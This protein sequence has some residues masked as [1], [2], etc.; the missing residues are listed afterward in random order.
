MWVRLWLLAILFLTACGPPPRPRMQSRTDDFV[1]EDQLAIPL[2][3]SPSG[4][5]DLTF[6]PRP[7]GA[8]LHLG[9]AAWLAFLAANEYGHLHYLGGLLQELG[10]RGQPG[11]DWSGCSVSLRVLRSFDHENAEQVDGARARGPEELRRLLEP[12]THLDH[13]RSWGRCASDWFDA[14]TLDGSVRPSTAFEKYLIQT[15]HPGYA[16]Q[17][18]SAG[19]VVGDG[20]AFTEGS[21]QAFVARHATLPIAVV[22]FR[23]TEPDKW[24]DVLV[25]SRAW[26]T[27][28]ADQGW[29]AAWGSIHRGFF[30]AFESIGE[31]LRGKLAELE[32]K[33]VG[34]WITG[35]SLGGALA[36]VMA[37]ELLRQMED[38]AHY[39]L[40]GVYTFGSPRVGNAAFADHFT[41][42]AARAG[43]Q[44]VR[45]RNG[46]DAVTHI[47]GIIEY[48]HVGQLV[49]LTEEGLSLPETE[50]G[51]SGVGSVGDHDMVGWRPD[52]EPRS[53]YYRRILDALAKAPAGDPMTSCTAP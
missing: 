45:F 42:A 44:V 12:Y 28:L 17:F 51:Y 26:K 2:A 47:P 4:G 21:T 14:A 13:P 49:H 24:R 48:R 15:V 8:A 39:D 25:D 29:P 38:G 35:H 18:F 32:G 22:S 19:E 53:G 46:E 23:G 3:K 37:A 30:E 41:E 9:N 27:P 11:F 40:R 6:C 16:L 20:K 50:P 34:I 7:A 52:G 10:F 1:E 43:V 36:T 33:P 31:V 5:A